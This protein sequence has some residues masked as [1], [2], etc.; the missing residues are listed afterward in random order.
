MIDP[1][2]AWRKSQELTLTQVGQMIGVSNGQ[3][4]RIENEG[5]DMLPVAMRLSEIT[6]LPVETFAKTKLAER[7]A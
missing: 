3:M 5:T 6:G 4:C 1:L 2:N 7:A